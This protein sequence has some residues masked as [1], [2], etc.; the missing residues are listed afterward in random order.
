MLD[1]DGILGFDFLRDRVIIDCI[2][3]EITFNFCGKGEIIMVK[4]GYKPGEGLGKNHQGITKPIEAT[5]RRNREG[6]GYSLPENDI[7][8]IQVEFKESKQRLPYFQ[9]QLTVNNL[10]SPR[11][12]TIMK[13]PIKEKGVRV[14]ELIRINLFQIITVRT[15]LIEE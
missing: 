11:T 13:I 3:N 2:K 9:E 7:F 5:Q 10:L 4:Q 14:R 8:K 15:Y 12:E 6:L 1:A